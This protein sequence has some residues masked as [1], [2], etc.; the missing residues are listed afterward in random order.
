M[1]NSIK[2]HFF[3]HKYLRD[4]HLDT[5]KNLQSRSNNKYIVENEKDFSNRKGSQVNKK[6]SLSPNKFDLKNLIPLLNIKFRPK[7]A[8]KDSVIYV[9]GSLLLNG[10]F[11]VELD[12]PWSLVGYNF[13][14][15]KFYKFFIKRI[16]LSSRCIE[17]RTISEACRNS[18]KEIFGMSVYR[19]SRCHYPFMKIKKN[20]LNEFNKNTITKLL[21]VSTQFEIKGGYELIS[22]FKKIYEQN[23]NCNLTIIS[24]IPD[25]I[26]NEINSH[27][28]INF[29]ESS[30]DREDI[31]KIMQKSDVLI[32]PTFYDTFGMVVLEALSHSLAI[33]ANDI[34]AINE[35][36]I[37]NVNGILIDPPISCWSNN[38]PSK[39][40]LERKNFKEELKKINK[41][42]YKNKLFSAIN[43]IVGDRD[44]LYKFRKNSEKIFI[45]KFN[46]D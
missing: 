18:L 32:L 15:I 16:L 13:N 22:T 42:E 33:V 23:T 2:I 44:L 27:K 46:S 4:R 36:C 7:N 37:N 41:S 19:K 1:K 8:S 3:N 14:G 38:L 6:Q 17:I 35:M 9:F 30:L 10:K 12:N 45:E 25:K 39:V 26:K 40:I 31:Y 11:I 24:Y 5:I 34:Y 20:N 21:F 43:K 28:A 29:I